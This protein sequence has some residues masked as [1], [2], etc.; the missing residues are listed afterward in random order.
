MIMVG[1]ACFDEAASIK[2]CWVT[3]TI[4]I[5]SFHETSPPGTTRQLDVK[6]LWFIT[7]SFRVTMNL[8]SWSRWYWSL[9]ISLSLYRLP[10]SLHNRRSPPSRCTEWPENTQ[11]RLGT[12]PLA[13]A[14]LRWDWCQVFEFVSLSILVIRNSRVV[15]MAYSTF[16]VQNCHTRY[17]RRH[18]PPLQISNG[19]MLES[20]LSS[21]I[22]IAAIIDFCLNALLTSSIYL[23][24]WLSIKYFIDL[25]LLS[26]LQR[27]S[28]I[29]FGTNIVVYFVIFWHP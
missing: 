25:F 26:F 29:L 11:T 27:L 10:F 28:D 8:L 24:Q 20:V 1:P 13:S 3:I 16:L 15:I 18:R 4:T 19:A 6:D 22:F 2:D 14:P 12:L 5:N 23:M 9:P 17:Q 7:N 21:T